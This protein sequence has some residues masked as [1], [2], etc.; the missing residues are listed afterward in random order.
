MALS[1]INIEAIGDIKQP[2]KTDHFQSTHILDRIGNTPL[3]PLNRIPKSDGI[4]SQVQILV[5]AE[6][7]NPGG[8]VKDRPALSMIEDG[9]ARGLLKPG[10]TILDATS[11][12]TGIGYFCRHNLII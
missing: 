6:Q 3:I 10:K 7:F 12:N 4:S 9:E 5:K 1:P 11:G 8:S 2:L